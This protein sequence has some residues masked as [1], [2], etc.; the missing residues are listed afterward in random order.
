[1][2]VD[3]E[4]ISIEFVNGILEDPGAESN[5]IGLQTCKKIMQQMGGSFETQKQGGIF[6]SRLYL[7]K[8]KK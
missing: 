7:P 4:R 8:I 5:E 3:D 6:I 2:T 1:M